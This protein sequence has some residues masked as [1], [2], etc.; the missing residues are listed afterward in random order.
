MYQIDKDLS[1][2]LA[3]DVQEQEFV[4]NFPSIRSALKFLSGINDDEE[5]LGHLRAD[6]WLAE[7]ARRP[8]ERAAIN[9]GGGNGVEAG[10]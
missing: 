8:S 5:Y 4:G 7:N 3:D 9:S 2:A 10:A 6:E 1:S